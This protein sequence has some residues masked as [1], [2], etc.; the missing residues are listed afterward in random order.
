MFS[1]TYLTEYLKTYGEKKV[2]KPHVFKL[3]YGEFLSVIE[4]SSLKKDQPTRAFL[5]LLYIFS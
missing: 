3:K 5:V 4:K 2:R 1:L